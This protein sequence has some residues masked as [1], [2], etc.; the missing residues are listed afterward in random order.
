ME[1]LTSAPFDRPESGRVAVRIVT[2]HG[3]EMLAVRE[4]P[5]TA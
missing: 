1:S 2:V 3:D 4:V 5:E